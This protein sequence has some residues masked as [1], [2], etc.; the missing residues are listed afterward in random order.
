MTNNKEDD[1]DRVETSKFGDVEGIRCSNEYVNE[2][3]T[4]HEK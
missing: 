4:N 1:A 2:L 3:G